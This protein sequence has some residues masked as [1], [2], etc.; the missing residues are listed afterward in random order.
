MTPLSPNKI[1]YISELLGVKIEEEATIESVE[2]NKTYVLD[3]YG[4]RNT[5][6]NE[7]GYCYTDN[8]SFGAKKYLKNPSG[9]IKPV[10]KWEK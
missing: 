6:N 8:T 1:I 4:N 9:I 3:D 10:I 5:F 7:T 2:G